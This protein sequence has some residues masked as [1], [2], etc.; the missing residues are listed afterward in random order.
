M[1]LWT[2][3]EGGNLGGTNVY[4]RVLL[5]GFIDD[6]NYSIIIIDKHVN[7]KSGDTMYKCTCTC[8]HH[9]YFHIVLLLIHMYMYMAVENKSQS[10][11]CYICT[12]CVKITCFRL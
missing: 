3:R 11:T 5:Y 8:I 4:I 1:S 9:T 10:K 6:S 7:D 2:T 12:T